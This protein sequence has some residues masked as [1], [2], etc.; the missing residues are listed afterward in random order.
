MSRDFIPPPPPNPKGQA[1]LIVKSF[2]LQ[3]VKPK[4]FKVNTNAIAIEQDAIQ[5]AINDN[6]VGDVK[7]SK[8]RFGL[9]VFDKVRLEQLRYKTTDGK[10]ITVDSIELG[11]VLCEITQQRNIVTTQVSG[12]NG[13][14]KEYIGDGDYNISIRGILVSDNQN[15]APANQ[16]GVLIGHCTS[17]VQIDVSSNFLS[18]F[19][20]YTIVIESYNVRQLEGMRNIIPFELNCISETPTEL[21][22]SSVPSFI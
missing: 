3:F 7:D 1:E 20:I 12:R 21:R 8:S 16:L 17:P 11:T 14:V 19:G 9:P 2:G 15:V 13:T 22:G 10:S 5:Q 4:F 18:Y 6:Q